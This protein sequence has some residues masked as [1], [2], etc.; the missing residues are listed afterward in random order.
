MRTFKPPGAY[1]DRP[2]PRYAR[3]MSSATPCRRRRG[4]MSVSKEVGWSTCSDMTEACHGIYC[5]GALSSRNTSL[6]SDSAVILATATGS[7]SVTASSPT[8]TK[9]AAKENGSRMGTAPPYSNPAGGDVS[10]SNTA[11][12]RLSSLPYA[13]A[14]LSGDQPIELCCHLITFSRTETEDKIPTMASR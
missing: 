5:G 13:N 11:R 1:R 3:P 6:E 14:V 4:R 9:T 12:Q 7:H 2:R 10:P 8:A